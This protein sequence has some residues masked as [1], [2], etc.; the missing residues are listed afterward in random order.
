MKKQNL[1]SQNAK[2]TWI[3]VGIVFLLMSSCYMIQ[4]PSTH[5]K[6]VELLNE[7]SEWLSLSWNSPPKNHWLR[8][9]K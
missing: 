5:K 2:N 6:N 4:S 7:L 8:R 1:E 3:H 9:N